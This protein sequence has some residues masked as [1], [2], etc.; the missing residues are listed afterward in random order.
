MSEYRVGSTVFV[1]KHKETGEIKT[2]YLD[3]VFSEDVKYEHIATIDP[4]TWIRLHYEDSL[5][6]D[7]AVDALKRAREIFYER[8]SMYYV[9]R[10]ILKN[11]SG[12]SYD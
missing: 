8:N 6:I 7:E 11:L 12:E 4:A 10:N 3:N 1:Y 9:I 2:G 5:K